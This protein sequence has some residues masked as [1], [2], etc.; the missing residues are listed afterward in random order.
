MSGCV[1]AF[2]LSKL[3]HDISLFEKQIDE[4]KDIIDKRNILN[5][6]QYFDTNKL[7]QKFKN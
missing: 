7:V 4:Y 2:L 3:G 1:S 6:P 5:G